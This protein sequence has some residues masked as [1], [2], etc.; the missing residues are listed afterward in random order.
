MMEIRP[1]T[2]D[3]MD[4]IAAI[5]GRSVLEE[6]ASFEHEPPDAEEMRRRF[7]GV[8]ANGY[9]YLVAE[10][11][12]EVA[13]Y[14]YASAHR[15]R[16]AYGKTAE[17]T[18]YVAPAHWRKGVAQALMAALIGACRDRGYR[19]VIAIVACKDQDDLSQNASVRLHHRLGFHE[20]G[21]LKG[22]GH[23]H[24]LWLDIVLLQLSL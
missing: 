19:Q 22:V 1:A 6:F 5:Y 16:P 7:E 23:K 3:D 18:V 13:G 4:Q 10:I 11:D 21:R 9:P 2:P 17:S 24:G 12:G 20:A 14:C 8:V 15:P